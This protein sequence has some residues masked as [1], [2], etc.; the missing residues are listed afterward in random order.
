MIADR[1]TRWRRSRSWSRSWSR[2]Q[3]GSRWRS[4]IRLEGALL[5][6]LLHFQVASVPVHIAVCF[7]P[8]L[9][10]L[11]LPLIAVRGE[12]RRNYKAGVGNYARGARR[13]FA[14]WDAPQEEEVDAATQ[15]PNQ[16]RTPVEREIQWEPRERL[17]QMIYI[18]VA[19]Y[20]LHRNS[21][22]SSFSLFFRYFSMCYRVCF[23]CVCG[24]LATIGRAKQF[25]MQD[26]F[27]MM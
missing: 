24:R 1:R 25:V 15:H 23:Y 14:S 12:G 20:R 13:A 27:K 10:L 11:C 8:M 7:L 9:L 2:S 16:L 18:R 17:F 22:I 3:S 5:L 26:N 6:C 19:K 4:L 21:L